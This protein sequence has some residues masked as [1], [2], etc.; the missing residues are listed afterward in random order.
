MSAWTALWRALAR[1]VVATLCPPGVVRLDL[2]DTLFHKTGPAI[3][4]AGVFRDAIRS[5]RR[6]VVY[7]LGLNLVVLTVRI[8]PPWGG[9]PL[10]L[11][12]NMRLYRKGGPTHVELAEQMVAEVAAWLPDRNFALACDGAYASLCGAG[13]ARTHVTSRIRRDA[14]LCTTPNSWA[15]AARSSGS[16][17]SSPALRA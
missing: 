7:A 17:R 3:E 10:G 16:P 14:A 2:D 15:A 6:K 1:H 5:T 8:D 9:E 12:V 4:G 11:P 13:L